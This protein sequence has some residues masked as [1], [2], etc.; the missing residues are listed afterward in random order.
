MDLTDIYRVFPPATV[1]YTVFSAAHVTFSKIDH[2]LDHKVRPNKY[3]KIE[4]THCILSDHNAIKVELD[5]K[6]S[7]R[8]YSSNWRLNNIFSMTKSH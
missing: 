8:K 5:N 1:Q 6:R 4:I 7:T 3:K 2:I